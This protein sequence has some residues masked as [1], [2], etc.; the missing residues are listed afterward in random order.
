MRQVILE[1]T[2]ED[3]YSSTSSYE[4]TLVLHLRYQA[5]GELGEQWTELSVPT[6]KE[7][8]PDG[9]IMDSE[10]QRPDLIGQKLTVSITG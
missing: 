1:A 2:I 9:D 8:E 10:H 5:E 4:E 6:G 7:Q 3:A